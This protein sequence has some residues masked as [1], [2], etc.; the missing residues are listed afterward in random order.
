MKKPIDYDINIEALQQKMYRLSKGGNKCYITVQFITGRKKEVITYRNR[1][2]G[3]HEIAKCLRVETPE[4]IKIELFVNDNEKTASSETYVLQD[5]SIQNQHTQQFQGFGEAEIQKMVDQRLSEQKRNEE[6]IELQQEVTDLNAEIQELTS[7]NEILE[8][9]NEQ[10]KVELESKKQIR[11][12]AGM[13]GDILEG[14]GISKDKIKSP[15]ASLMGITD[16]KENK[17]ISQ[18]PVETQSDSSG[19]VEEVEEEETV[20]QKHRNEVVTLM[21]EYLKTRD[22]IT[23]S[24]L[25]NIFSE[26]E[27][28]PKIAFE[29]LQFIESKKA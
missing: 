17:E 11:Y 15:I 19:I 25:F 3:I 10:L 29:I 14:I 26:V 13:L 23:L 28:D 4:K 22:N 2:K 7:Q 12:Y 27:K 24:N 5:E 16:E 6:F 9:E 21:T 8:D 18:A 1:V 20:E